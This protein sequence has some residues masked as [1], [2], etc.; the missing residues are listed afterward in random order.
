MA[1][2]DTFTMSK[3][4]IGVA[5][6]P[7]QRNSPHHSSKNITLGER[8]EGEPSRKKVRERVQCCMCGKKGFQKN[9][10]SNH[11]GS[12]LGIQKQEPWSPKYLHT[13]TYREGL[14]QPC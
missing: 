5:T 10:P 9:D 2:T 13:R 1:E 11:V 3:Y 8:E 7:T 12:F 6:P 14:I 4:P